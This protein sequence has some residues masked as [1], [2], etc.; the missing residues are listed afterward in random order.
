M[1]GG[2]PLCLYVA[3]SRVLSDS[4]KL[5]NILNNVEAKYRLIYHIRVSSARPARNIVYPVYPL[6]SKLL[7]SFLPAFF[8]NNISASLLLPFTN[9][10]P[11]VY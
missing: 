9:P 4:E 8:V 7:I 11:G 2:Y 6:I 5:T 1:M 3:R 10:R